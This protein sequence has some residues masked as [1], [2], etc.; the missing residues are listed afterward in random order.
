[1]EQKKEHFGS[2]IGAIAALAGSAIGVGNIWKFPYLTGQNGGAAF[3]LIYIACICFIGIPIMLAEFSIGRRGG[4][5]VY[6]TF[7]TL[8][9]GTKWS[10]FSII[11]VL[12]SA[13][14]LSY[15]GT[16]AGW[17]MNYMCLSFSNVF[18][19]ATPQSIEQIFTEFTSHPYQPIIWQVLFMVLTAAVILGGVKNGIER[20]AKVMMPILFIILIVLCFRS[21]TINEK[22]IDGLTFLFK[23]NLDAVSAK[24][25]LA[26]M[27]QAF[28]SLSVGMGVIMTYGAYVKKSEN[29]HQMSYQV[30]ISDTVVAIL[31]GVAILPATFAF[32][33]APNAGPGLVFLTLPQV[34]A[35]MPLGQIWSS[36]F[37]LLIVLAA[38]TS[39]ISLLEVTVAYLINELKIKR[40]TATII[41]TLIITIVGVFTTLAFGPL[42]DTTLFGMNIFDIMDFTASN[43]LLPLGGILICYFAGWVLGK[44]SLRD[45]ITNGNK[46]KVTLFGFYFFIMKYIAPVVVILLM[47]NGLGVFN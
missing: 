18:Q 34:F 19:N 20:S 11:T 14:I 17:T 38:L 4:K 32:G 33:M 30:V 22:S 29:I 40:T 13:I 23:P 9:P 10:A 16:I 45:E 36:L 42:K 12:T 41:T 24:T 2:K 26:A 37:F 6:G 3:I 39:S 21:T 8:A 46:I 28:F 31:A 27:G 15:Y 44:D 25:F 47:L 5:D 35:Q 43:I 1:M 7:K